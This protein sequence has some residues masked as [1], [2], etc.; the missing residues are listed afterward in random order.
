[1][2]RG[3]AVRVG[4]SLAAAFDPRSNSLNALRLGLA[5][6]VLVAHAGELGGYGRDL[7]PLGPWAVAGFFCLSGY[8][9]TASRVRA[10]SLGDF[11]WRR[12]L[13]IYPA[14]FV[15]LIVVAFAIAPLTEVFA[16]AGEWTATEALGYVAHNAGVWIVQPDIGTML[17]DVPFPGVWNGSLWTLG[18]EALCYLVIGAVFVL[19]HPV[20]RG[21][22]L[23]IFVGS[24][25]GAALAA[26][27]VIVLPATLAT[28]CGLLSYFTAGA[29]LFLCRTRVP[30]TRTLTVAAAGVTLALAAS[31]SFAGFAG[32]PVA[33]LLLSLGIRLPLARVGARHDL[34]YGVYIY[35]FP[36]QQTLACVFA[37]TALPL[38]AFV[39]ISTA[40][41]LPLAGASWMLVER[42]AMR[43]KSLGEFPRPPRVRGKTAARGDTETDPRVAGLP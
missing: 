9:I 8:L 33:Y 2:R 40:L 28:F 20:R 42:P 4:D 23:L 34:S 43:A 41:A 15:V 32:L 12:F 27:G 18:Y 7:Q 37:G 26:R 21:T 24:S 36:V 35:A 25:A 6:I 16:G 29:V 14:F 5:V 17:S 30:H 22:V 19:P 39:V 1:M 10:R 13:R 11:L 3:N 38:W 31:D